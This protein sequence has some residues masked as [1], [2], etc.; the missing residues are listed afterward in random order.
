MRGDG[1]FAPSMQSRARPSTIC[2]HTPE[3]ASDSIT[4]I[5]DMKGRRPLWLALVLIYKFQA[6]RPSLVRGL[7]R[8]QNEGDIKARHLYHTDAGRGVS[9]SDAASLG[10]AARSA[11]LGAV[12]VLGDEV[13]PTRM[14][15]SGPLF[16]ILSRSCLQK[17]DRNTAILKRPRFIAW[18]G[19][20]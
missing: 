7:I 10:S 8:A 14:P 3:T 16:P 9:T 5:A 2:R 17:A 15:H 1:P 18:L 19:I 20:R 13:D 6:L 11:S 12:G 4:G